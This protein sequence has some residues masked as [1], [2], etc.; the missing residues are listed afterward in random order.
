MLT[1]LTFTFTS[2]TSPQN[3][4]STVVRVKMVQFMADGP[5]YTFPPDLQGA[6]VQEELLS[7]SAGKLVKKTLDTRGKFRKVHI[8]LTSA[9]YIKYVDADGNPVFVDTLLEEWQPPRSTISS[10]SASSVGAF[11]KQNLMTFP[12]PPKRKSLSSI[13]KDMV[14][15][16]F[17][18]G[19]INASSW[20]DLFKSECTCLEIGVER[21]WEVIRP[22]LEGSALNWYDS[23]GQTLQDAAWDRWRASFLDSFTQKGWSDVRSAI[24]F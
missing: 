6:D 24:S 15:I 14:L 10:S 22:F 18:K 2:E 21:Y 1:R 5:I 13:S 19:Q 11:N 3:P 12:E 9:L 20:I 16:K 4:K 23:R 8:T 17:R 7:T